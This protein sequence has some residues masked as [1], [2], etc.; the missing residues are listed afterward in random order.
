VTTVKRFAG[1][2]CP[3]VVAMWLLVFSRQCHADMCVH[4]WCRQ[5]ARL[6]LS[7]PLE[8]QREI[9]LGQAGWA[10][11]GPLMQPMIR[12][13]LPRR[14][15]AGDAHLNS[16][17]PAICLSRTTNWTSTI[18]AQTKGKV[19]FNFQPS[20][21]LLTALT[22]TKQGAPCAGTPPQP[23][24]QASLIYRLQPALDIRSNHSKSL[25]QLSR[26][27]LRRHAAS[28]DT[29]LLDDRGPRPASPGRR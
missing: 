2:D 8:L 3:C 5:A 4:V 12:F 26:S 24:H 7:Q 27:S 1:N 19:P 17:C 21:E 22:N 18:P 23:V 28:T 16:N 11:K 20:A 13:K 6:R 29:V 14:P 25:T 15:I 9:K 10:H